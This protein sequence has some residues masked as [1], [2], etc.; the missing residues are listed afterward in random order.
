MCTLNPDYN[1]DNHNSLLI[2]IELKTS[3]DI[4]L[5]IIYIM[6]LYNRVF[7]EQS[8]GKFRMHRPQLHHAKYDITVQSKSYCKSNNNYYCHYGVG[9]KLT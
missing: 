7:K 5:S 8:L 3:V 1:P 4:K 6:N 9:R 2:K